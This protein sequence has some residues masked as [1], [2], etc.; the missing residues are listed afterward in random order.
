MDTR[1]NLGC[2]CCGR[3]ACIYE[4]YATLRTASCKL[5]EWQNERSKYNEVIIFLKERL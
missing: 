2:E 1:G 4:L 5:T 3:V